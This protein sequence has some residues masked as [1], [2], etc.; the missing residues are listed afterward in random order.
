MSDS[1]SDSRPKISDSEVFFEQTSSRQHSKSLIP[2]PIPIPGQSGI[3]PESESYIT[4]SNQLAEVAPWSCCRTMTGKL[5]HWHYTKT[6][7]NNLLLV[8]FFFIFLNL[9]RNAQIVF[10]LPLGS[11]IPNLIF[12][13]MNL[14][15]SIRK[16]TLN[17]FCTDLSF[18]TSIIS[19]VSWNEIQ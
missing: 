15:K 14:S 6:T 4:V 10:F 3:I 7:N 18:T 19:L 17:T 11:K 12:C 9:L 16:S 5:L 1:D 2:I 8:V 13:F